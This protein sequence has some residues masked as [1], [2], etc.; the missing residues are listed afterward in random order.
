[1]TVVIFEPFSGGHHT[2]YVALLL[3]ALLE[4]RKRGLIDR[5]VLATSTT[6]AASTAFSDKLAVFM[7]DVELLTFEGDFRAMPGHA[8]T[9]ILLQTIERTQPDFLIS[10]S[11]NNGAMTL[12]IGS[13][14]NKGFRS[15][16]LTSI[17]VLHNGFSAPV[18]TVKDRI[19]D[20]IHRF[21]RR[22]APWSQTYVVNPVL[23]E[24]VERQGKW[25][26]KGLQLLPDPVSVPAAMDKRAARLR[27]GIPQTGWYVGMIGQSDERKALP[28]LLAAFRSTSRR[29]TD[30]LLVAGLLFAPFRA[31]IAREYGDLIAQEKLVIIDRHLDPDEMQAANAACDAIATTYYTDELSSSL[32]A[33]VAARRPV[34]ASAT[35]YTGM[36]IDLFGVGWACDVRNADSFGSVLRRAMSETK[37][38]RPSADANALLNFHATQNFVN[39]LLRP[40]YDRLAVA[41]PT[42]APWQWPTRART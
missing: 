33:A 13:R 15:R 6:H 42:V 4:L 35:G 23:Y 26:P 19:R 20:G 28:E 22:Y 17:G 9:R 37:S 30:R 27:L 34:V 1:V 10:T 40:L 11:A 24:H 31:L 39:T 18:H 5:V 12:A 36:M 41:G 21:S 7:D 2:K 25:R 14:F 29:A 38:Y 8:V 3:P 16:A 32:L